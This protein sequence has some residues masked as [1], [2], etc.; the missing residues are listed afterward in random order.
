MRQ[1]LI[2]KEHGHHRL[3]E[4]VRTILQNTVQD[5]SSRWALGYISVE[6]GKLI[7]TDGRKL[8]VIEKKHSIQPGL[9][10]L[11]EDGFLLPDVDNNGYPKYEDILLDDPKAKISELPLHDTPERAFSHIV[12]LLNQQ[13]IK[14]DLFMMQKSL[15]L[16]LDYDHCV[17]KTISPDGPFQLHLSIPDGDGAGIVYLQMPIKKQEQP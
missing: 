17:L 5:R 10:F 13:G 11:T 1:K 6:T 14:F 9:Y 4:A 12:Y 8:V 3:H 16:S 7:A 2:T 15:P